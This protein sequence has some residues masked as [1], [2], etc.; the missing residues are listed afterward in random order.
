MSVELWFSITSALA[1]HNVP[2]RSQA[3]VRFPPDLPFT[4][5][6]MILTTRVHCIALAVLFAS[7][8]ALAQTDAENIRARVKD[9]Q[10]V[11]ITDDQGQE[12]K[13]RIGILSTNALNIVADGKSVDVPYDRIVRVDR[14][15]DSLANGALIGLGAGAALGFIAVAS[16]D[17]NGDCS[18]GAFFCGD[19]TTGNYVAGTFLMG[20]LGTAVGVGIDALIHHNREIYRRGDR[21]HTTVAPAMGRG[22]RGVVVSMTW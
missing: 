5:E 10:K 22:V 16:A 7:S 14:P 8:S 12:F 19:A 4:G 1:A 11:S 2:C 3:N 21:A 13:G 20:G 17:D 6:M 15:N 9:G 18:P